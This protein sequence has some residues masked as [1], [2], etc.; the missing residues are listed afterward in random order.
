MA[1]P[2]EA[3]PIMARSLGARPIVTWPLRARLW[4]SAMARIARLAATV[5]GTRFR[6]LSAAAGS[7]WPRRM[8][9]GSAIG[10]AVGWGASGAT[11]TIAMRRF[12]FHL[13]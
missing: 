13:L 3:G 2:L 11:G 7:G 10:A 1:R 9:A 5:A 6:A 4:V 12:H 8:A